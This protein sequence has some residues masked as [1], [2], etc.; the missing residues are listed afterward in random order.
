MPSNK[1]PRR[2]FKNT[3][4]VSTNYFKRAGYKTLSREE[5]FWPN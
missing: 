4:N 3:L 1:N 2:K 5:D